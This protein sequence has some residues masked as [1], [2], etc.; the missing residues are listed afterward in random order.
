MEKILV[1]ACLLGDK[2]RYDGKDNFFPFLEELKKHYELVA[3][4]PE[5]AANL[6]C[7]R[8]KAEIKNGRVL[9]E[10][11]KDLT[12]SYNQAA[13]QAVRLC[14]F[15]GI[16]IAILKDRSPACGSR[17]IHN[18][19]FMGNTIEG[20]GVTAQALI[21]ANVKVYAETDALDFLLPKKDEGKGKN[22]KY[23]SYSKKVA[24]G[25]KKSAKPTYK[26]KSFEKKGDDASYSKPSRPHKDFKKD[27]YKKDGFK[28]DGFKKDNFKKDRPYKK[29]F[30]GKPYNESS[31]KD[32]IYNKDNKK[33][34]YSKDRK[35]Y[36]KGD[37][38]NK[39]NGKPY[40]KKKG[41]A[42]H[43]ER[44]FSRNKKMRDYSS[45]RPYKKSFKKT[46][47]K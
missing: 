22:G 36:V 12:D 33:R 11:G 34:S 21:R 10:N 32:P 5:M 44:S 40:N 14:D 2:C 42:Y 37:S 13:E 38:T 6:G 3:F 23:K 47:G 16:R 9:T 25:D 18:G 45:K 27:G 15:L 7:P 31:E 39:S 1:S 24:D 4:C 28:K 8:D 35:P 41:N 20:L 19:M 26:K 43:N 29:K 46:E 17:Y 30:E